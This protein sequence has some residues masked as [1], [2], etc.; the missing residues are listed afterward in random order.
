MDDNKAV[1][2]ALLTAQTQG[3]PVAL[4][5][6]VSVSGSVPRHEGSKM[7]VRRD[8]SIVG[9]VGGGVMESRVIQEALATLQDGQ[10]RMPSYTDRKSVV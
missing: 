3:E 6:V 5:T 8:S 1:F 4:A 9:T 10:T 2:E 7:L